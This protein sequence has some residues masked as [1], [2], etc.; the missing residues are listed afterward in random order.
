M[1]NELQSLASSYEQPYVV[2]ECCFWYSAANEFEYFAVSSQAYFLEPTEER[3]DWPIKLDDWETEDATG[4]KAVVDLWMIS[5]DD[6]VKY[7]SECKLE[8][9]LKASYFIMIALGATL[10]VVLVVLVVLL[11]KYQERQ[12]KKKSETNG[13]MEKVSAGDIEVN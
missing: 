8:D 3:W 13:V 11:C 5:E 4:Y 2:G 6:I 10:L 12:R 9:G 7:M 1:S